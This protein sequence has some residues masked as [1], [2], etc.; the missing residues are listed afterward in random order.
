MASLQS[1]KSFTSLAGLS[2]VT[3]TQSSLDVNLSERDFER[4]S[5]PWRSS[6]SRPATPPPEASFLTGDQ[7]IDGVGLHFPSVLPTRDLSLTIGSESST[8][9]ATPYHGPEALGG[10]ISALEGDGLET[11]RP[12]ALSFLTPS[13]PAPQRGRALCAAGSLTPSPTPKR[14]RSTSPPFAPRQLKRPK[15]HGR[16]TDERRED[17]SHSTA[18]SQEPAADRALRNAR[19]LTIHLA[20]S[21]G[22]TVDGL[23]NGDLAQ[24]KPGR[25]PN[26]VAELSDF[27]SRERP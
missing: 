9:P 18:D 14:K 1:V 13:G 17:E 5:G 8:A 23:G 6:G 11:P 7:L 10:D 22:Y 12:S 15:T 20:S 2:E 4:D 16:Q 25:R 27:R 19:Q 21:T 24:G 26:K 3:D